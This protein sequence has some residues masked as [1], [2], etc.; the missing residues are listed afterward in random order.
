VRLAAIR[1]AGVRAEKAPPERSLIG[2]TARALMLASISALTSARLRPE[3]A[4]WSAP[5]PPAQ[6]LPSPSHTFPERERPVTAQDFTMAGSDVPAPGRPRPRSGSCGI[7]SDTS[8]IQNMA[9]KIINA[10]YLVPTWAACVMGFFRR[11]KS[12]IKF[13]TNWRFIDCFLITRTTQDYPE[14]SASIQIRHAIESFLLKI[15][16]E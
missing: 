9:R 4:F 11:L 16:Y 8:P 10:P 12:F 6:A 7:N 1:Y 3:E 2:L 15:V 13:E 5:R 14:R